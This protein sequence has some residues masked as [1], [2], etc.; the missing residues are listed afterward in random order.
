MLEYLNK[1]NNKDIIHK[2]QWIHPL[3]KIKIKNI[4]VNTT[5][6]ELTKKP[7]LIDRLFYSQYYWLN[8]KP[9]I[10]LSKKPIAS[11]NLRQNIPIG[12]EVTFRE[13]KNKYSSINTLYIKLLY[14][15]IPNMKNVNITLNGK[16]NYII[17]YGLKDLNFLYEELPLNIGGCNIQIVIKSPVKYLPFY[18]LL[19]NKIM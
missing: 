3:N 17:S 5:L 16:Y 8:Q 6:N 18:Y 9:K 7:K 19:N 4:N 1:R 14:F 10:K 13:N 2:F 15:I 11:F 12:T